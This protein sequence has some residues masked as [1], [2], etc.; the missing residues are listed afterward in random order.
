MADGY[1]IKL[2]LLRVADSIDNVA[3]AIHR[4]GNSDAATPLGAMEAFSLVL[5]H[6]ITES[7]ETIAEAIRAE[8]N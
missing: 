7:A 8:E 2:G 6:A 3:Q 5:T 4:L 1:E